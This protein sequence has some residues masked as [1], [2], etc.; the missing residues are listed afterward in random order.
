MRI[1]QGMILT[2]I[3]AVALAFFGVHAQTQAAE[4]AGYQVI[5]DKF[6]ALVEQG[7]SED[8]IDY[9]FSTNVALKNLPGK[10][11]Q[12]KAQFGAIESQL[13]SYHAHTRLAETKVAGMFVYQHYFVAYERQPISVRLKFYKA[14]D[15]WRVYSVAFDTDLPE[16]IEKQAE[17]NLDREFK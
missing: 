1:K 3:A 17:Q 14:R 9:A 12:L 10:G 11:D 2:V 13:G 7:K 4:N 6:F 16:L 5:A 8:A 15:T